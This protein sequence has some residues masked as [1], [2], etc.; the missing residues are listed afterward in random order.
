M[1]ARKEAVEEIAHFLRARRNYYAH[2]IADSVVS[3]IDEAY[4]QI[5]R[6]TKER[7]ALEESK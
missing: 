3:R 7:D 5:E 1:T 6:L 4:A 2:E